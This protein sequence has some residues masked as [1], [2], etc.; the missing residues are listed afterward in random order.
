[1]GRKYIECVVM[2][3]IR[4]IPHGELWCQVYEASSHIVVSSTR[5]IPRSWVRWCSGLCGIRG[6]TD[7]DKAPPA[8]ALAGLMSSVI[9]C[10][11]AQDRGLLAR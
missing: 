6:I 1:M 9:S 10:Q 7:P 2:S 3:S 5:G 4:T 11:E 8:T